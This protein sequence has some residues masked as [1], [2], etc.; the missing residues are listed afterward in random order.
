MVPLLERGLDA[1]LR[2]V[3]TERLRV[4]SGADWDEDGYVPDDWR[5]ARPLRFLGELAPRHSARG[6]S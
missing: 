4:A 3:E 6:V 5:P 1:L 2:E